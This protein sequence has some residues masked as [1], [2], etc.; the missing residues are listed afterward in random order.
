MSK[1]AG[2]FVANKVRLILPGTI[3]G[4]PW[5]VRIVEGVDEAGADLYTGVVRVHETWLESIYET[6]LF[7]VTRHYP[8]AVGPF[9]ESDPQ[10]VLNNGWLQSRRRPALTCRAITIQ[11]DF[12]AGKFTGALFVGEAFIAKS[13]DG[14]ELFAD[15]NRENA[16]S[17]ALSVGHSEAWPRRATAQASADLRKRAREILANFDSRRSYDANDPIPLA[18]YDGLL[19]NDRISKL[20]YIEGLRL[21]QQGGIPFP[22]LKEECAE[23]ILDM[24]QGDILSLL[25]RLAFDVSDLQASF[26]ERAVTAIGRAPTDEPIAAVSALDRCAQSDHLFLL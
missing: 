22:V 11:R 23:G 8:L 24:K 12:A 6:R 26:A 25:L 16:I 7:H 3:P 2:D 18:P 9:E 14:G 21:Y 17:G 13:E 10:L 19:P 4:V 20:R 15:R 1:P 5:N